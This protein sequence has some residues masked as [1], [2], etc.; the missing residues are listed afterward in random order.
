[1]MSKMSGYVK[2]FRIKDVD[3]DKNNKLMSLQVDDGKLLERHEAICTKTEDLKNIELNA[4]PVYN[5]R[6][7]TIK[8]KTY[9]DKVYIHFRGLNLPEDDI[10]YE[11]FTVISIDPLL[12]YQKKYYLQVYL[13]NRA[14]K[15]AKK[16]QMNDYF[17]NFFED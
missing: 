12:V 1:M 13:C 3:K 17:D 2:I 14:Y 16:K 10:E 7:I 15:L 6:Y 9:R 4:L 11:S 8:I 5:D